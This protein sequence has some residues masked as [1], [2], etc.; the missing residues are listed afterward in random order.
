MS[1]V[2]CCFTRYP[3]RQTPDPQCPSKNIRGRLRPRL[4]RDPEAASVDDL[5]GRP[6][7]QVMQGPIRIQQREDA[8]HLQVGHL[9][10]AAQPTAPVTL[11]L[12]HI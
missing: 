9:G 12:I 2:W 11:S 1:E 7:G 10:I 4:D 5:D 8:A 6:Q 3:E